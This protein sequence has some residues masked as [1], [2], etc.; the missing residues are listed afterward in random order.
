MNEEQLLKTLNERDFK[1]T[2]HYVSV[3]SGL[4]IYHIDLILLDN[5]E[6]IEPLKI[7]KYADNELEN[8][9]GNYNTMREIDKTLVA[10]I[11]EIIEKINE[12]SE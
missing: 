8:L 6:K 5:K 1:I 2:G 11:N 10:K 4:S 12:E 7:N 9:K 3:E